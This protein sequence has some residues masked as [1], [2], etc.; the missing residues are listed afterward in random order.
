MPGKPKDEFKLPKT[1]AACADLLYQTK[2]ARLLLAKQ[3][4]DLAKRETLLKDHLIDN[5]PKGDASG[6][7]G[8]VARVSVET[9]VIPKVEDWDK[10][11]TFIKKTGAWELLGRTISAT[12]VKE[13]WEAKKVVPGVGTFNAFTVSCTK[14]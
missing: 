6:I 12:A 8:K 11:H 1:L 2:A 9:K 5:L 7:A 10:L 14:V 4:D 3:V 13:R